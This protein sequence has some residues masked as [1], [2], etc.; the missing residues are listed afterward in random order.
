M[1]FVG[2]AVANSNRLEYADKL[3]QL[4]PSSLILYL[5]SQPDFI[6]SHLL[7]RKLKACLTLISGKFPE[8]D[9]SAKQRFL[10]IFSSLPI[11]NDIAIFYAFCPAEQSVYWECAIWPAV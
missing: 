7:H 9:I 6:L 5:L 11:S 1:V 8:A 2:C 4:T 3:R 10:Q